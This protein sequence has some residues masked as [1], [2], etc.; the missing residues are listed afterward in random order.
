MN[1][2]EEMFRQ[3]E[4]FMRLLQEK[5]GF[6]KFPVDIL[7]KEG[8]RLIKDASYECAD[9][10]HEA[11]QHLKNSKKHR[12]TEVKSFDREAYIEEII[13]AQHYLIEIAIASGITIEEFFS[14]YIKKGM[15]NTERINNGY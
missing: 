11:R 15:I 7:S 13:D 14:A 6:P 10:L 12:A 5:R 3:Q 4:R 1:R 9:E 8:Q 2:L